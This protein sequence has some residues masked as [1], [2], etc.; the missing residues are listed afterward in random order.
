V[1]ALL[2]KTRPGGGQGKIRS[3]ATS[4]PLA[5]RCFFFFASNPLKGPH[6][7]NRPHASATG[8]SI[9]IDQAVF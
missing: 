9:E 4:H 2:R 3:S 5:P 7:E 8:H 1:G 6:H